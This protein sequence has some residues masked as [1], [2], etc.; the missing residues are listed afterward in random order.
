MNW[1]AAIVLIVLIG[2]AAS[3]LRARYNSQAGITEDM[4]GNQTLNHRPDNEPRR[5]QEAE[6]EIEALKERIAVLERIAYDKNST[7]AQE[8]AR[9]SAEIDALRED[10]D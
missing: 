6:R 5:D 3:V 7:T 4:M 9:I 2:A 8:R 1:A 10:R